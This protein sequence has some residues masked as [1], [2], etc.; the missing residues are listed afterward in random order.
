MRAKKKVRL[1]MDGRYAYVRT[2][3][4]GYDRAKVLQHTGDVVR[5]EYWTGGHREE[6]AVHMRNVEVMIYYQD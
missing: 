2:T 4:A 1:T 3:T 6:E 5:L